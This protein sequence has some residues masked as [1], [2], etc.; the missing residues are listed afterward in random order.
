ML[1]L[2]V[3]NVSWHTPQKRVSDAITHVT[4]T[5]INS[6]AHFSQHLKTHN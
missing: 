3:I 6:V 5:T 1:K 4:L 2:L